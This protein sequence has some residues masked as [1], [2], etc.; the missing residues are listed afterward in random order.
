MAARRQASARRS[1]P[2]LNPDSLSR[3]LNALIRE[4]GVDALAERALASTEALAGIAGELSVQTGT[5]LRRLLAVIARGQ[6]KLEAEP[7]L[8]LGELLGALE[9]ELPSKA[10][11]SL[12]RDRRLRDCYEQRHNKLPLAA[13]LPAPSVAFAF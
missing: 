2:S 13:M 8:L 3:R 7:Q 5:E 4:H 6:L 12:L 9:L 1:C 10:F 11:A